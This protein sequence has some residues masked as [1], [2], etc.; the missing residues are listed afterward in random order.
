MIDAL[1]RVV[2]HRSQAQFLLS[3]PV[4]RKICSNPDSGLFWAGDT[5]QTIAIGSAFRFD[6]LKSFLYRVEVTQYRVSIAP[7]AHIR[8][9]LEHWHVART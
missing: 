2:A 1:G 4:I 8:N 3:I 5:A 9:H 6:D 7:S